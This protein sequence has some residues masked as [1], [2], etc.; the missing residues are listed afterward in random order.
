MTNK[1]VVKTIMFSLLL[2]LFFY[3]INHVYKC[4]FLNEY[5][6]EFRTSFTVMFILI[7]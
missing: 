5:V 2:L 3:Q 6:F 7:I 1:Q 4:I